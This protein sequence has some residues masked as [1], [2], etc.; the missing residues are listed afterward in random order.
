M[1]RYPFFVLSGK[2]L[3]GSIGTLCMGS[4][5]AGC[6]YR[7]LHDEVLALFTKTKVFSSDGTIENSELFY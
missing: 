6:C 5:G 3:A 2:K 1:R 7:F 4:L